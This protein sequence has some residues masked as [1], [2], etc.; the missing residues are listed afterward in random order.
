[1]V[2]ILRALAFELLTFGVHSVIAPQPTLDRQQKRHYDASKRFLRTIYGYE[3]Y[4]PVERLAHFLPAHPQLEQ[5]AWQHALAHGNGP[6][7]WTM[8]SNE[9]NLFA[10]TRIPSNSRLGRTWNLDWVDW[11]RDAY[12]FWHV[13]KGG[14]RKLLRLDVWPSQPIPAPVEAV[15]AE[16]LM[17]RA[18]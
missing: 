4:E 9:K 7:H 11:P 1:M 10:T 6:V 8:S 2:A 12:A 17:Q 14:D 13:K 15:S 16:W 18:H 5:H 3:E